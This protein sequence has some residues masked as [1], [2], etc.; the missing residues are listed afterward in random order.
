[1]VLCLN[2]TIWMHSSDDLFVSYDVSP[3]RQIDCAEQ[4]FFSHVF[5]VFP[6]SNLLIVDWVTPCSRASWY[7]VTFT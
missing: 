7:C 3:D 2:C 1:M 5:H 6:P 4:L